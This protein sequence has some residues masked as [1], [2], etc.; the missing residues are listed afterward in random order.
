MAGCP[1]QQGNQQSSLGELC[2]SSS[3]D[4]P[5]PGQAGPRC[6]GTGTGRSAACGGRTASRIVREE[7]GGGVAG[8]VPV[9]IAIALVSSR[10][11]LVIMLRSRIGISLPGDLGTHSPDPA[12]SRPGLNRMRQAGGQPFWPKSANCR[13]FCLRLFLFTSSLS[14]SLCVFMD[15]LSSWTLSGRCIARLLHYG[16]I[17]LTC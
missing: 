7:G 12:P 14:L 6:R 10:C 17:S 9:G 3:S 11:F 4:G 1:G 13:F 5:A 16:S 2:A 8:I 15:A